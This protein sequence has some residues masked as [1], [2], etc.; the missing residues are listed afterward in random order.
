MIK[1]I[2]LI[3]IVFLGIAC[4]VIVLEACKDNKQDTL[5]VTPTEL[6]FN[7]YATSFKILTVE[8]NAKKWD[9]TPSANWII[10]SKSKNNL[11]VSV[12]N[13][14]ETTE[15]RTGYITVEAGSADAV[16]VTVRQS[17]ASIVPPATTLSISSVSLVF[18]AYE[19]SRS[20]TVTTNAET[21]DYSCNAQWLE[22]KQLGD[23]LIITVDGVNDGAEHWA[24]V[25]I[26]ANDK[27]ASLKVTQVTAIYRNPVI[28]VSVPDPHVVHADDGYFYLVGTEDIRNTPIFRSPDL[29]NWT[30]VG[31]AF[32]NATRPTFEPSGGIWAPEINYVN[33]KYVLYY[34]MSVWGGGNT[35]GI[36]VAVAT[37]PEGPY[38][39]RGALFRSNTI[40]VNNSID[41]TYI[42]D[43]GKKYL[44]WG[45][46]NGI[47]GV[48]LSNDGLSLKDASTASST[49]KQIA[50]TAYEAPYIHKHG[51]YYY[52]FASIGS[53]CNQLNSTYTT[54]VGRSSNLWGPYVDKQNRQMT[55][56]RHE[57]F[58][59]KNQAFVGPGHNSQI[60]QD[61]AG[62]DW[63][64]YHGWI[65]ESGAGRHVFLDKIVW[66]ND[67]PTI[68]GG[69]PSTEAYVPD[70]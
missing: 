41:A 31:T 65:M 4:M 14:A 28:R 29:V 34:S 10:L 6:D 69:S 63:I 17:A 67:W 25:L 2:E 8:T 51:A 39:D 52:L 53:C 57:V 56:N 49:K 60:V 50:G 35:C 68:A 59:S 15:S 38:T 33:E 48:E 55:S 21:W 45:S 12:Q 1:K 46:W 64:L 70:L 43:N 18:G 13:Y 66:V 24:S 58:I 36:G 44:F 42:E 11:V 30:Q 27:T 47:W 7:A 23:E 16:T 37:R 22:F 20:V 62:N 32:T 9:A 54:V 26:T 5:S 19:T 3:V 40:G 61:N